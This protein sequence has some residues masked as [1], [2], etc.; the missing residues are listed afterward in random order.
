MITKVDL[1]NQIGNAESRLINTSDLEFKNKLYSRTSGL[2]QLA[3]I[4]YSKKI[5]TMPP[6]TVNQDNIIIDGV[7]RYHAALKAEQEQIFA[8]TVNIAEGDIKLAGLMI[9]LL[10][11]IRHPEKD[12]K[13]LCIELWQPD[14]QY[15]L[16]LWN[17]LDVPDRTGYEWTTDIR[18]SRRKETNEAIAHALLN[19]LK[20]QQQIADEFGVV[21][22]TINR[23]KSAICDKIA[24]IAKLS[25]L[26]QNEHETELATIIESLKADDLD[27]LE[28]YASFE[29][30]IYNIFNQQNAD[31]A[32]DY[33]G[34]F[35]LNFMKNLLYYHTEPFD[36]VYDPF[37]GGGTS[38]DACEFMFRQWY[39]SDLHPQAH[40]AN[41]IAEWNIADGLP[42]IP[43]PD[44]VFL[45]PPYWRQASGKYSDDSRDLG[46]Q[47][48]GLF[49][50]LLESFIKCL[51]TK[52]VPCIALVISP[53]QYPN[54]EH[55]L[56]DHIF[57]IA[58][59][60]SDK[61]KI[62]MRYSLPYST[63]QYNG[64]QVNI[65]KKEKKPI[66]LLRD[67]V[68]WRRI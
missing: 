6:I 59:M 1:F 3:V 30:F 14:P 11:G 56:E 7:H 41:E 4:D 47:E 63:Q 16:K 9:D 13:S 22:E 51:H 19:P 54:D 43:K 17:E 10:S 26:S 67:L 28:E 35:P 37:V 42:E 45:D 58:R 44:L 20:N 24:D 29:P 12:V 27:F 8:K 61:Y 34:Q 38:I 15:N 57:R 53:T 52:R 2:D 62:E 46:N 55:I 39:G 18:K 40:R 66:T 5:A 64:N 60:F 36:F 65:M 50:N 68:V 21:R 31:A 32:N 49:Y 25:L 23:L 48:L 33:Y